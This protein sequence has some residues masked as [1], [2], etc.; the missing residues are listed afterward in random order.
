MSRE[1]RSCDIPEIDVSDYLRLNSSKLASPGG[2]FSGRLFCPCFP[3]AWGENREV[4][5]SIF[6]PQSA[7]CGAGEQL[8]GCRPLECQVISLGEEGTMR[9][10]TS[11]P[12]TAQKMP[13]SGIMGSTLPY[14]HSTPDIR[15]HKGGGTG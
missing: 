5:A 11:V 3:L 13:G 4:G 14:G 2:H 10:T 15:I 1:L 8:V 6:R 9:A 12:V 7:V